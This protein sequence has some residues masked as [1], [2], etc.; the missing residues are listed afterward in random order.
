M[1]M[2][3]NQTASRVG[4]TAWACSFEFKTLRLHRILSLQIV[5]IHIEPIY[6]LNVGYW[7]SSVLS[8]VK[9]CVDLVFPLGLYA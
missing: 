3:L 9:F 1:P 7:I 8:Y 2:L 5:V 4:C 6:W